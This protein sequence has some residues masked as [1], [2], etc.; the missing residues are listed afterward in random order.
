MKRTAIVVTFL[1]ILVSGLAWAQV[2]TG[3][4]S[5]T[6]SDETGGVLPGVEIQVTQVDTGATRSVVSDDEGRYSAPSLSLGNYEV[7]AALTGFQTAVRSGIRLT[8]GRE[9]IVNVQ[10]QIGS[11]SERVVVEAEAALVESTSS[12]VAGLVDDQQIRDL[13]L[14]GRSFAQLAALQEGVIPPRNFEDIQPGNEGAKLSIGGTR[15]TQTAF[16]I[17]GTDMRSMWGTTPGGTAGVLLGVD[18]VREFSVITSAA[19]A[20]FGLFTGGVV[21]AVSRSGTNQVHGSFFEFHRNSALDS[22]NFFDRD[23]NNPL[24][25]KNP[26]FIRNQFGFTLGG[27]IV[28]DKTFFFGSYEGLR[29]RKTITQSA[30]VPDANAHNGVFPNGIFDLVSG[31]FV[32]SLPVSPEILPYLDDYPLPNSTDFGNGTGEYLFSDPRDINEDFFMFKV[33]HHFTDSDSLFF[34]YNY[35]DS[36]KSPFIFSGIGPEG[37]GWEEFNTTRFQ[38]AT[39]GYQKVISPV[40]INEATFGFNRS[41]IVS[42]SNPIM[43]V[44]EDQKF[45]PLPDR[46]WGSISVGGGVKGWGPSELTHI[47]LVLN[48]FEYEDKLTYTRGSH[49]LK[50]GAKVTRLQYNPLNTVFGHGLEVMGNLSRFI[51]GAP[52]ILLAKLGSIDPEGG[53][54]PGFEVNVGG[55][56]GRVGYRETFFGFFIQDDF[57]WKPNFTWNLGLRYEFFTNPTEIGGRV[58]DLQ[59]ISETVLRLGNPVLPHNPSLRNFSPRIGFAWD[60]FGDGKTSI[61]AGGGIF[62]DLIDSPRLLGPQTQ[63]P[64]FSRVNTPAPNFPDALVTI[65][66]R[67]LAGIKDSPF[68]YGDVKQSYISQYNLTIQHEIVGGT[69]FSASYQGSKGT[70]LSRLHDANIAQE[71]VVNGRYFW[72]SNVRRNSAFTQVRMYHW[73]GNS[74]YNALAL[75]LRKRFSKGFQFQLSYTWSKALDEASNTA[76]SDAAGSSNGLGQIPFDRKADRGRATYDIRNVFSGNFV[77]ELPFGTGKVI[78]GGAS[79]VAKHIISGWQLGGLI[80]LNTGSPVNVRVSFDRANQGVTGDHGLRPD[81]VA[82]VVVLDGGREPQ[83]YIDESSFALSQPGFWGTAPRN[84]VDGPGVAVVDLSLIKDTDITEAVTLQFRAEMFNIFNRANFRFRTQGIRL[85]TAPGPPNLSELAITP[86]GGGGT[87]TSSRQIQIALKL[88]F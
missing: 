12:T 16:L 61:R 31:Q 23:P 81:L 1:L 15:I 26:H 54:P 82:P 88:V 72:P 36:L 8:V 45:L 66:A 63:F 10:L 56:L 29:E 22:R 6:V 69:V 55:P 52:L 84:S 11:I 51:Q 77:V 76:N 50:F 4:I 67:G 33:D 38:I 27:P 87:A 35:D 79:G 71:T 40:L 5:G 13:P 28:T 53:M 14:N 80:S 18:T 85:W 48:R 44:T 30:V 62:Y 83:K 32:F 73:D 70:K 25:R 74:N 59:F 60:P 41:N 43:S 57:K 17:D 21:N 42:G 68:V 64:F 34:R 65:R 49:S 37:R 47:D 39:I 24:D 86:D 78:G 9:A 75:G 2:T 58:G 7:Q 19:S 20:E 3:T 46:T